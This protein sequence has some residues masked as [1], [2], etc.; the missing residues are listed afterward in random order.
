M[1][2]LGPGRFWGF[3]SKFKE[4]NESVPLVGDLH[5]AV[6][7]VSIA[8]DSDPLQ[9][10]SKSR[11]EEFLKYLVPLWNSWQSGGTQVSIKHERLIYFFFFPCCFSQLYKEVIKA[12]GFTPRIHLTWKIPLW[13]TENLTRLGR[14][15]NYSTA[16]KIGFSAHHLKQP[17]L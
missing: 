12:L 15:L 1:L 14:R 4:F 5:T 11:T 2:S 9:P 16:S 6:D 13:R 10:V 17:I 7:Y 3:L 8:W